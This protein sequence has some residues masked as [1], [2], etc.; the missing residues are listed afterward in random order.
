MISIGEILSQWQSAGVFVYVLPFLLIFAVVFGILTQTRILGA[1][2]GVHVVVALVIGL[3][4][5]QLNF[6]SQFFTQ[7]FPRLGVALAVIIVAA[8]MVG[9]FIHNEQAKYWMYGLGTIGAVAWL[10]VSLGAFDSLG[11][12]SSYNVSDYIGT[13]IG[14]VLLI[15]VIIAVV[16]GRSTT[17]PTG[18]FAGTKFHSE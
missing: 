5:L 1:N 3:L 9:L 7:I 2:K 15:G 8:I 14:A 12:F 10:I 17:T 4:A 6:V 16:A 18:T 11:W 13:I